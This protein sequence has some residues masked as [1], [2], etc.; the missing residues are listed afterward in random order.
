MSTIT[1]YQSQPDASR[2]DKSR[3]FGRAVPWHVYS[4][5]WATISWEKGYD[6]ACPDDP[7]LTKSDIV[8]FVA[9]APKERSGSLMAPP[10]FSKSSPV[11]PNV[12]FFF[13]RG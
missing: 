3:K 12:P 8:T 4:A 6:R 7:T 1:A 10:R 2:L 9:E 13:H 5:A 11:A